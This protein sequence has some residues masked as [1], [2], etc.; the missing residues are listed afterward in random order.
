MTDRL[1]TEIEMKD[2]SETE[3]LAAELEERGGKRQ[4]P[5]LV[6]TDQNV[7]MYESDDIIAH[8]QKH[9]GEAAA[10][11]KPRV[12]VGGSTCESCEG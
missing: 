11:T 7:E 6:D 5:Y 10:P 4:V 1:N 3:A 12:H 8:L 2:I 9:Y